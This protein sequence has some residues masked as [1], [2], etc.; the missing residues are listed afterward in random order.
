MKY[1]KDNFKYAKSNRE[2]A[3]YTR[4]LLISFFVPKQLAF[5]GRPITNC[6]MD[7]TLLNAMGFKQPNPILKA[8]VI[9][10]SL[11]A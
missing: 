5:L 1:E 11:V 3:N 4:D 8:F 2:V 6:L 7:D 10:L 9:V